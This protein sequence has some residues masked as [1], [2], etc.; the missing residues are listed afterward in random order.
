[1]SGEPY[2]SAEDSRLLREALSGYRGEVFMEIGAGNGGAV[3]QMA[4]KFGVSV[5]VDLVKPSMADWSEAGGDFVLANCASCVRD[6]CA[7][8]VAF[9]P[10]YL[11]GE[12]DVAVEGGEGLEVPMKFLKEA[13]RVVKP[14][15]RVVFL[16]NDEARL[17]GFE[18]ECSRRGFGMRVVSR[19]RVFF[20]ELAV[21]EAAPL[22]L[23]AGPGPVL[24]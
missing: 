15:G 6:G 8:L 9:N 14:E 7:D 4:G 19:R 18:E 2:L 17:D 3:V 12:G 23:P 10:P 24:K 13:L 16:L 11:A 1:M 21:Y 20:E 22:G 5:G